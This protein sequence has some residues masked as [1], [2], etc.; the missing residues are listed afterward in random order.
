[1][2][3][4]GQHFLAGFDGPSVTQEVRDL[5]LKER[6]LG[7]TLFKWNI[8]SAGQLFELTGELKSLAREAGYDL[9]IAVDQEGGRVERLPEPFNRIPSMRRW[10]EICRKEGSIQ[11]IAELGKILGREVRLAGFN[12]DFA[13]VV[14]VDLNE[15]N[16]IIGDRSFSSDAAEVTRYARAVIRGLIGEGVIPCL[17]HFPGHGA[18]SKDSHLELPV[19]ERAAKD[20]LTIDVSPYRALFAEGL[21]P[22]LMTA[23]VLYPQIDADNPGTLSEKIVSKILRED[24]AYDGVVFSDDLLMKAIADNYDLA[25]VC[26]RFFLIGGDA[27][28]VCKEPELTIELIGKIRAKTSLANGDELLAKL[29]KARSRLNALKA[30]FL[31]DLHADAGAFAQIVARHKSYVEKLF[32]AG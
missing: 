32:A 13:P 8:E 19:D 15:A 2:S 29:G 6:V 10:T 20:I 22:A 12:L 23:H 28:L 31:P 5:I 18:T 21:V 4:I 16:P 17:K 27:A 25:E 3:F 26:E 7:F 30:K 14:D 9:L 24:L 11:P 1:M